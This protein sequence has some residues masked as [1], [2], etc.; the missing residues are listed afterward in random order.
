MRHYYD[1]NLNITHINYSTVKQMVSLAAE[2]GFKGVGLAVSDVSKLSELKAILQEDMGSEVFYRVNL[3]LSSIGEIKRF[4]KKFRGSFDIVSLRCPNRKIF[5]WAARDSRVDILELSPSNVKFF[6]ETAAK[7][8]ADNDTYIEIVI[9]HIIRSERLSRVRVLTLFRR[10]SSIALKFDAKLIVS[11][12]AS[13][14]YEMRGPQEIIAV[15]QLL[16][17]PEDIA[18]DAVSTNPKNLILR[19]K[20]KMSDNYVCE[21]VSVVR[22]K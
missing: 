5:S 1:L 15:S 11:S 9:S 13:S 12:G 2:L 14:Y 18:R 16:D 6:K 3:T 17:L 19:N 10:A 21:G 4:L 22:G 8:A 20:A 7:L